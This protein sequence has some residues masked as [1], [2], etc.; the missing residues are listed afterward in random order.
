ML[1]GIALAVDQ[2]LA[3][4]RGR[5]ATIQA[6]GL[7]G[8]VRLEMVVDEITEIVQ[9]RGKADLDGLA[10]PGGEVVEAGDAGVKFMQSLAHGIACPAQEEGRLP[11]TEVECL[12]RLCHEASALGTV[13]GIRG[14]HQPRTHRRTQVHFVTSCNWEVGIVQNSSGRFIFLNPPK[15]H[16]FAVTATAMGLSLNQVLILLVLLLGTQARPGRS[17][18]QRWIKAAGQK[19]GRVLKHLDGR[20]R[21]LVLVGCLDEI[22]FHRRP[23][24]VG[25]EP[26]SMVWFLGSKADD[27]QGA[28]WCQELQGWTNLRFVVSDA[29]TG[30]QAGIALVQQQR[31][32]AKQLPLE[33]GY[34]VFHT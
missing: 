16:E 13:E 31:R 15:Q 27:R 3:D 11:L 10:P 30:L 26:A 14:L 24:L 1:R 9:E 34:D 19:A 4:F 8:R 21:A 20:C 25:V 18:I 7:E 29:G 6:C 5:H 17:T 12:D 28:T 32:E 33:N 23:V 2:L 22:F